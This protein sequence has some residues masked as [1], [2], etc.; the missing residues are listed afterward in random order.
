[1][2]EHSMFIKHRRVKQLLMAIVFIFVLLGGWF[3][4]LL[5]YFIPA[6]MLIGIGIALS[7]GRKW[8][9][10]YCPRGSF[11]DIMI[12]PFSRKK[13]IPGF[14]KSLPIRIG[15]VV[16][17]MTL[18]SI[19]IIR[20]WPDPYSIGAFFVTMLTVTTAL[21]VIAALLFH[22]RIWCYV[23]PIGSMSNWVGKDKHMLQI[24]S[25]QCVECKLCAKICPMQIKPYTYKKEGTQVV[26]DYDC[27]KCGSCVALCPK[28]S[29]SLK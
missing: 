29:L 10:W 16:L 23:C 14:I 3:Y 8:C 18:M 11:W 20:R 28:H 2:K 4:P 15:V 19:Q 7:K 24:N 22:Q 26:K 9:D 12:E 17:L 6:C 5:G 21:G 1:M 13:E 25:E 27:L